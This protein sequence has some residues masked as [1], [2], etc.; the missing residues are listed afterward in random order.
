MMFETCQRYDGD[1]LGA[2]KIGEG[3]GENEG[4]IGDIPVPML[5]SQTLLGTD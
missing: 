4:K 2:N 3:S 1:V 5:L